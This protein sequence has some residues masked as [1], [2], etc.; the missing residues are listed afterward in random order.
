AATPMAMPRIDAIEM[1]EMKPLRRFAR[2]YRRPMATGT[3][4]NI[5]GL[6]CHETVPRHVEPTHGRLHWFR[7]SSE[8]VAGSRVSGHQARVRPGALTNSN[9]PRHSTFA[10]SIG[11]STLRVGLRASRRARHRP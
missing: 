6:W 1:K 4:L 11:Q 8:L 10:P 5:S 9:G 3:G 2:R 7:R